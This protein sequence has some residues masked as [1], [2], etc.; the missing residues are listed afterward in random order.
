MWLPFKEILKRLQD[1]RYEKGILRV[2]AVGPIVPED[3]FK[4]L[5]T[6][7]QLS[8]ELARVQ[9]DLNSRAVEFR[10]LERQFF[11]RLKDSDSNLHTFQTILQNTNKRLMSLA[12]SAKRMTE[13]LENAANGLKASNQLLADLLFLSIRLPDNLQKLVRSAL[14]FDENDIGGQKWIEQARKL[15]EMAYRSFTNAEDIS[16]PVAAQ[17]QENLQKFKRLFSMLIGKA[18]AGN[19]KVDNPGDPA[20]ESPGQRSCSS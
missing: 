20:H 2:N 3:Y 17:P 4:Q 13:S 18:N 12:D 19:K 10:I 9:A 16:E 5:D 11:I 6:F 7:F 1:V 15:M 8:E 14:T